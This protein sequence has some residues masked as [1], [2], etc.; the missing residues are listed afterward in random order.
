MLAVC[1]LG[2]TTRSK[3]FLHKRKG[4][5]VLHFLNSDTTRKGRRPKRDVLKRG[6]G[7]TRLVGVPRVGMWWSTVLAAVVVVAF[8]CAAAVVVPRRNP[9]R[10]GHHEE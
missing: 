1:I 7:E 4:L 5:R 6:R 8:D 9:L 2:I 3:L 10:G